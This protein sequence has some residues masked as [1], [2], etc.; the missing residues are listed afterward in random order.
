M[1][2]VEFKNSLKHLNL[3]QKVAAEFL[4]VSLRSVHGFA[5]SETVPL[6]ISMLL[7]LMIRL[8]LKA[9]DVE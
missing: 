7:R 6:D 3:T 5:N 8:K 1:N 2:N 4:G 9:E